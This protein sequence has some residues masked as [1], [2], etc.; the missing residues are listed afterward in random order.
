MGW[1]PFKSG[2]AGPG[3][4]RTNLADGPSAAA[5]LRQHLEA[6]GTAA[7]DQRLAQAMVD[8]ARAR[9][10]LDCLCAL[11]AAEIRAGDGSE[12]AIAPPQIFIKPGG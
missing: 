5:Y 4:R 2:P 12:K 1:W 6:S 9:G 7:G 8:V 10:A 11:V 3:V